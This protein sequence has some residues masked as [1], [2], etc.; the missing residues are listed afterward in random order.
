MRNTSFRFRHMFLLPAP[1]SQS[2]ATSC[3]SLMS[4]TINVNNIWNRVKG[5]HCGWL[6]YALSNFVL[7]NMLSVFRSNHHC[8]WGF[9]ELQRKTPVLESLSKKSFKSAGPFHVCFPLYP[10]LSMNIAWSHSRMPT[11]TSICLCMLSLHMQ[12]FIWQVDCTPTLQQV[13]SVI[14]L[15]IIYLQLH[16]KLSFHW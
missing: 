2:H 9:H 1:S 13:C 8:S 16:V 3:S 11:H 12:N 5:P 14:F 10:G 4:Q 15:Q 7:H 6:I